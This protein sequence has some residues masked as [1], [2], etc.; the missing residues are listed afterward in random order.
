MA[1]YYIDPSGTDS[2][3]RNGSVGQEWV[4]LSYACSRV[5]ASGNTIFVNAGTYN[6]S[7][8]S[9]L[10]VGV[11]ID[12]TGNT[13]I[14]NSTYAG[15]YTIRLNSTA[16]TSGN[17]TISNIK[18]DGNS[19][20]SYGAIQVYGRS[21]V[22]IHDCTFDNFSDYGCSFDSATL[23]NDNFFSP[24]AS[25][26]TG[27]LFY[28]NTMN[29]CG[30][31]GGTSGTNRDA[32]QVNGQDGML[33]HNNTIT[34]NKATY[35]NGNCIGGRKGYIKNVKI[36]NNTLNKTFVEGTTPWDFA[37]EFWNYLGGV[38]IYDNNINGCIDIG[39]WSNVK[40]SSTYSCWI[41]HNNIGQSSLLASQNT[42]GVI[43]EGANDSVIVEK[44]HI[45]NV[46]GGVKFPIATTGKNQTNIRISYNLMT[47][48]GSAT[49]G[50]YYGWG[51]R[52]SNSVS[53]CNV[54]NIMIWNNV[55]IGAVNSNNTMWGI[56]LPAIGTA[57][58]ISI[59]NNIIE[60]FEYY[61][62][63]GNDP[64]SIGATIDVLNIDNNILYGNISNTINI[65]GIVPTNYSHV[66]NLTSN[67]L[68]ISSSNFHL[69]SGS[70]AKDAG[71]DV[72]LTSDYDDHTVPYNL[73]PD[74]GAFEYFVAAIG[75]KHFYVLCM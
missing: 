8:Q 66:N 40:G 42:V 33:I 27:N 17:Q 11:N 50:T 73:V 25:F 22:I 69:Q 7:S 18:M 71:I 35:L 59:R 16:G 38:E 65:T 57:S 46:A 41:H 2:A 72:G 58:N 43:I 28:N 23:N 62:I 3:G 13:S 53:G 44:N 48:I 61:P 56:N 51:I 26:A 67:P 5:T 12:G 45:F 14:I 24:P 49:S 52:W 15:G 32:L 70:P 74:I 55:I 54:D 19:Y 37:I 9:N 39:G 68:F 60:N 21:D 30:G 75:S 20:T 29:N 4:S 6:E 64:Q 63:F 36:Y 47:N 1:T 34:N 31:Q 10:S